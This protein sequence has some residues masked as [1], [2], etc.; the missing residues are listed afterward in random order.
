MDQYAARLKQLEDQLAG[1]DADTSNQV[2]PAEVAQKRAKQSR[3]LGD[4]GMVA[5]VGGFEH[6]KGLGAQLARQAAA[7]EEMKVSGG[8]VY[9]PTQGTHT[10]FPETVREGRRKR[11]ESEQGR[12]FLQ[13]QRKEDTAERDAQR[14]ADRLYLKAM[15]GGG[16]RSG[17]GGGGNGAPV[18]ADDG[19]K[20]TVA[21]Q[22]QAGKDELAAG[23]YLDLIN[24]VRAHVNELDKS[25]PYWRKE[26]SSDS[27]LLARA[28][29][30]GYSKLKEW[31]LNSPA[32]RIEGVKILMANKAQ[33]E[34]D[35]NA[36]A[37]Q[38][39]A[40][41]KA[42]PG[43]AQGPD[44][45]EAWLKDQEDQ[46]KERSARNQAV[47]GG[48]KLDVGAGASGTFDDNPEAP[49]G[50]VHKISSDAEYNA[51]PKG[52]TFVGPDGQTRRKP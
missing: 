22:T 8:G 52:A 6:L 39:Q 34:G 26:V 43:V 27:G 42:F 46:I 12:V 29:G 19:Q 36:T 51:L 13:Q 2:I 20:Y 49:A 5:Q 28:K 33:R 25:S 16:R 14:Q 50:G 38:F 10:L 40:T 23:S 48:K 9:D 31:D 18:P 4:L 45:L 44:Q 35:S 30:L 15:S 41:L 17:G 21:T 24:Q 32:S 47:L 3:G 1:L 7:D 37:R 11:M